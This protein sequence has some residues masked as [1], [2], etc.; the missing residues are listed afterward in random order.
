M[1][2]TLQIAF[3]LFNINSGIEVC[4]SIEC[5]KVSLN[6]EFISLKLL[7]GDQIQ[8]D[9]LFIE[10]LIPNQECFILENVFLEYLLLP[11]SCLFD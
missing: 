3:F 10:S 5:T 7:K 9:S 8:I 1:N 6:D 4:S 11:T 2:D